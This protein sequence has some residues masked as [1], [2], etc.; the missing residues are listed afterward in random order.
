MNAD[1]QELQKFSDLAHRWW[2]PTSEFRPLHEINPLRLEWINARAAL[3]GKSVVDVGCGGGILAESMARKGARVT[4]IDLSDKALKVADLHGMESG[5]QVRYEKIAAEDL[6]AREPGQFDVVTCM[7]MLEHVPDPA[8][9]VRACTAMVKPG[10][11]VFF[12][13]LNRNPKAYLFAIIGA[14]YL[15]RMLPRG[16]HDYA[17]FITPAELARFIR[18]AGLELDGLKGLTYNPLTK[19]YSINQDTSVNYMVACRKPL[20]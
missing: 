5:V 20:S 4:G 15:L 6:A 11:H 17:K 14:E 2:D 10:G 8:S 19:L 3:S 7:E 16:T 1:P 9:I 12:S 13:T 18:E